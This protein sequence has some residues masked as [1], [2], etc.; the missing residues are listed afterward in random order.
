[1]FINNLENLIPKQ[2]S[3]LKDE[4]LYRSVTLY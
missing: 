2:N 1:M 4:T 3:M